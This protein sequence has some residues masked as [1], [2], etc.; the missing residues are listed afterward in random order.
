MENRTIGWENCCCCCCVVWWKFSIKCFLLVFFFFIYLS[1]NREWMR[2]LKSKVEWHEMQNE[3]GITFLHTFASSRIYVDYLFF[4]FVIWILLHFCG[5]MEG[6]LAF[7]WLVIGVQ[8]TLST[9]LHERNL[10][11]W[12]SLE[13]WNWRP[14]F[15]WRCTE[16]IM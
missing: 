13:I 8:F 16:K 12:V 11:K 3:C 9:Y 1:R 5:I 14:I 7:A 15:V 10:L 4:F 2:V 6:N